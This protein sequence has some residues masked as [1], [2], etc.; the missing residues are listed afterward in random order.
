MKVLLLKLFHIL[1]SLIFG[2]LRGPALL[3][4]IV[5]GA[6]SYSIS[7]FFWLFGLVTGFF[8]SLFSFTNNTKSNFHTLFG[9]TILMYACATGVQGV[10][11]VEKPYK[12]TMTLPLPYGLSVWHGY[13]NSTFN[14]IKG[15]QFYDVFPLL[16]NN[17]NQEKIAASG[18]FPTLE[19][20]KRFD[21]STWYMIVHFTYLLVLSTN[22][23]LIVFRCYLLGSGFLVYVKEKYIRSNLLN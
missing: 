6:I 4:A 16:L 2:V 8:L 15:P 17:K 11:I 19:K 21:T 12:N 7:K 1:L 3:Y 10:Y 13:D 20:P 18:P 14:F 23:G 5:V 9:L 22:I